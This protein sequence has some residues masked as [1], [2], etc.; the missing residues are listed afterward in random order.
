MSFS[1][2]LACHHCRLF[3]LGGC[4]LSSSSVRC[5]PNKPQDPSAGESAVF[6]SPPMM[7]SGALVEWWR[8]PRSVYVQYIGPAAATCKPS[9]LL[10]TIFFIS[11]GAATT[12][13]CPPRMAGQT[14]FGWIRNAKAG[15]T[16]NMNAFGGWNI[17]QQADGK[18]VLSPF[19]IIG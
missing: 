14:T 9:C 8:V 12:R 1:V 5:D 7:I 19:V 18:C 3:S 13:P 11:Q 6:A 4:V 17:A 2:F 15:S 16:S 10:S